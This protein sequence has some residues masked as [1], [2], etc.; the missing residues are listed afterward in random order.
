MTEVRVKA[1]GTLR[2]VQASGS[3]RAWATAAAAPAAILAYVQ[4]FSVTSA[5]TITTIMERGVPDHHKVTQKAPIDVTFRCL[6]TGGTPTALTSSGTTIPL[7]H[8]EHRASAAEIGN[9]STG[10]FHQFHGAALQS[11]QLQEADEGNSINLTY[12]CLAMVGPT[13]SGFL[14]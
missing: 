8:L 12:R 9:G 6:W 1:E 10:M 2:Q 14:S 4:E 3:G 11:V 7:F 5:Q 13:G